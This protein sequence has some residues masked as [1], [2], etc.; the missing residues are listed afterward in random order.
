M[1]DW[2]DK[3]LGVPAGTTAGA[4][5]VTAVYAAA[6]LKTEQPVLVKVLQ[7]EVKVNEARLIAWGKAAT[8]RQHPHLVPILAVGWQEKP[9][10][11]CGRVSRAF[12]WRRYWNG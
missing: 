8:I 9:A 5:G 10:T 11:G 12:L 6:S 3:E 1:T 2:T 4:G 7:P